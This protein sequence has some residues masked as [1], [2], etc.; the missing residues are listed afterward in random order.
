V[1]L[2]DEKTKDQE[3]SHDSVPL[4]KTIIVLQNFVFSLMASTGSLFSLHNLKG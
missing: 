1:G 2:I 3:E 4:N